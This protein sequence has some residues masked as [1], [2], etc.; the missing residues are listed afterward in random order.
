MFSLFL[1]F[2]LLLLFLL[3]RAVEACEAFLLHEVYGLVRLHSLFLLF[4]EKRVDFDALFVE[5]DYFKGARCV[6][7]NEVGGNLPVGGVSHLVSE[8]IGL[9]IIVEVVFGLELHILGRHFLGSL[10][11]EVGLEV[12]AA[13]QLGALAGELLGVHREILLAG[14]TCAD[15][16]EVGHPRRAA[17]RTAAGTDTADAARFLA[18]TDLL[19]L[20]AD[21]E[22][23]GKNTDKL[24]EVDAVVGYI[25]ENR[26]SS[27]ALIFHIADLHVQAEVFGDFAGA[28]HRGVLARAGLLEFLEVGLGGE[29]EHSLE[30]SVGLGA[31]F[32]HL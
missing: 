20:H 28:D 29:A 18:G 27:V 10:D 9:E 12:E 3:F 17:E 2:L 7:G 13:F 24:A 32:L 21:L 19:H 1:G 11:I 5:G 30:G 6:D 8:D 26:L 16:D 15:G 22:S 4:V 25:I 23:V 14:G 31:V